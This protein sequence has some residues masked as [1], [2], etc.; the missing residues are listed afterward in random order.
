M[1]HFIAPGSVFW[2]VWT[3]KCI[4]LER[5][6]AGNIEIYRHAGL[7][8]RRWKTAN[9]VLV[10]NFLGDPEKKFEWKKRII[11]GY[12]ALDSYSFPLGP[13]FLN[14]FYPGHGFSLYYP[15][16]TYCSLGIFGVML[17][18]AWRL[19]QRRSA[20]FRAVGWSS[21]A[22]NFEETAWRWH[23]EKARWVETLKF[24]DWLRKCRV[25]EVVD[26]SGLLL[27]SFKIGKK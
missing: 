9:F 20:S 27:R 14:S 25:N 16:C 7:M 13:I 1:W 3:V 8:R 10:R 15:E 11:G 26:S 12:L 19:F 24:M 4:L 5:A 2:C 6:V 18:V 23:K 17:P 21:G 22:P